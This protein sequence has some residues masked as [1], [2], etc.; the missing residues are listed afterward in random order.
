MSKVV[1]QK[2]FAKGLNAATGV[3]SQQPGSLSRMSNL[4]LTQRGSLQVCDGTFIFFPNSLP[5]SIWIDSF[6]NPDLATPTS[7]FAQVPIY[8][9][10]TQDTT[11]TVGAVT[12]VAF[13]TSTGGSNPNNPGWYGFAVVTKGLYGETSSI[14]TSGS[15]SVADV[16]SAFDTVNV[17]W[18]N[19]AGNNGY[20]IWWVG[21]PSGSTFSLNPGQP[22]F[23]LGSVGAN[24]TTFSFTGTLSSL[25]AIAPF[26]NSGYVIQ[27]YVA[28]YE[29]GFGYNQA[30]A[31][32]TASTANTFPAFTPQPI[33]MLPGDPQ[34]N[35]ANLNP[36]FSPYGGF[37]GVACNVPMSLQFAGQEIVILG[38][39]LPPL[40][41]NPGGGFP[42]SNPVALTNT[43][44]A[45]YPTWQSGVSWLTGSQIQVN[46]SGTNYLFT[47]QVG[48][49]SG[50]TAPSWTF[51]LG[52]ITGDN[53]VTWVCNGPIT[54]GVA[55]R[56][57]AHAV[58]YAG[59]LW[60]AN[61]S[62]TTTSDNLD[63][64]SCLKMSD[65]N[66][67]NSWNPA[68]TAFIGQDD[69]TQIT[70]MRP[71][72]I[73]ALGISPT[74]SMAVFKEY[75]TYQIIGV[76][77][78]TD[79]EIQ[80]AQTDMGC[81]SPRS[82]QFIPGFGIM[83]FTHLGF[84]VYE[85][86]SDRLVSEE[87]RPYLFGGIDVEAD[88]TP[89]DPSFLYLAKSAQSVKPPMYMCAMPLMGNSGALTRIFC[90]DLIMKGWVIIDL[91]WAI[92]ALNR[93]KGGEGLPLVIAGKTDGTLQRMQSGDTAFGQAP[94]NLGTAI[95]WNFRTPDVF[96]EGSSQRIFYRQVVLRGYATNT[97][98]LTITAKMSL[99]GADQGFLVADIVPQS[100]KQFEARFSP[101]VNGQICHLDISGQGQ[102]VIDSVDWTIEPKSTEAR[103]IIG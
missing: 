51:T 64:P 76:F 32:N 102:I 48:G 57:A 54:L 100:G 2:R 25:N 53:S 23:K 67:P 60:L 87:I 27:I 13:T 63:G 98:A 56:G 39:G 85:G 50:A 16:L 26:L 5:A 81:I 77:G 40:S 45:A 11:S 7:S 15:S 75:Q 46:D 82:I 29:L 28:L 33:L 86:V 20:D 17:T 103:R 79:F 6:L 97:Q 24:V 96:G 68:N 9:L 72:T 101:M 80:P 84:A 43:F 70:G 21:G 89:I 34:F 37:S 44:S 47:A 42:P 61:T 3:L 55:P 8:A 88:I 12:G 95:N 49:V 41:Y 94:G 99:D 59:S 36:G 52:A 38:N 69:G 83:R 92:S 71:F 22:G 90:Y 74:G 18:T 4:L 30:L 10:L 31:G 93:V 78:S 14:L 58:S 73:A 91:P 1:S 66:N 62:P 19:V 65:A 35:P